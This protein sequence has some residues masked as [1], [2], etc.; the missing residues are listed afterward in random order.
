MRESI[1]KLSFNKTI[2]KFKE[3]E[4]IKNKFQSF[5]H[6]INRYKVD[7]DVKI[8][9]ETMSFSNKKGY[10]HFIGYKTNNC[11]KLLCIILP[12]INGCI[13]CFHVFYY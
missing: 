8:L 3:F 1:E 5:K 9:C 6:P 12:Q 11:I 4:F 7:V 2:L 13:I 10:T